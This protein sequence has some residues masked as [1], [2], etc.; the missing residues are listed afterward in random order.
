VHEDA[1]R[2][3]ERTD[4][5]ALIHWIAD[6]LLVW[7]ADARDALPL[8][9]IRSPCPFHQDG[10]PAVDPDTPR[11]PP[12]LARWHRLNN[13]AAALA[14]IRSGRVDGACLPAA[15]SVGHSAHLR[16]MWDGLA[17]LGFTLDR[18]F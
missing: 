9:S 6:V 17:A 5:P 14:E 16:Q 2:E 12:P 13:L 8:G 7:A 1:V 15:Y 10:E 3:A 18:C 4:L 11:L